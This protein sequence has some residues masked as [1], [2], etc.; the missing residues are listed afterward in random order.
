MSFEQN[1]EHKLPQGTIFNGS[2]V[3]LLR[4]PKSEL[5]IIEFNRKR[6]K[7]SPHAG[8]RLF[9]VDG[10]KEIYKQIKPKMFNVHRIEQ[11]TLSKR[12]ANL[13][14]IKKVLD[15]FNEFKFKSCIR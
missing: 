1:K 8:D 10:L 4:I 2:L 7:F 15:W 14:R 3:Y 11:M 13:R 6:N 12:N 5:D 9:P